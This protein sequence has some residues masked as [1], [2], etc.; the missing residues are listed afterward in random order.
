M[1]ENT[2]NWKKL[3][4]WNKEQINT[5]KQLDKERDDL[6]NN[7]TILF[8]DSFK[9]HFHISSLFWNKNWKDE[10]KLSEELSSK[11][12]NKLKTY[13]T[14]I[15]E[16]IQLIEKWTNIDEKFLAEV[17][18]NKDFLIK[19]LISLRRDIEEILN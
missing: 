5:I 16:T 17:K 6:K 14:K 19:L 15:K 8:K 2:L 10:D 18:N 9:I 7:L 4:F 1:S 3:E 11:H 12:K 13:L